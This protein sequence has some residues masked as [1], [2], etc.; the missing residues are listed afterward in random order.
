MTTPL[1]SPK[2]NRSSI[3][4]NGDGLRNST[5]LN[6]EGLS[7]SSVNFRHSNSKDFDINL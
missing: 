5:F 4:N 7:L 6:E 3:E 1:V 2:M